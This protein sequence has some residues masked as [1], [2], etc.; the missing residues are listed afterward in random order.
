MIPRMPL[1]DITAR[2]HWEEFRVHYALA[3][4][5][6]QSYRESMHGITHYIVR[7]LQRKLAD[8][9]NIHRRHPLY[10]ALN[11]PGAKE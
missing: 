5:Q 6:V 3:D 2:A 4:I 1:L 10:A 11:M 7:A 8:C 9:I